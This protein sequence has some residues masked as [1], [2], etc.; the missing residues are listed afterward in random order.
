MKKSEN[1][2]LLSWVKKIKSLEFL[3]SFECECGEKNITKLC[4]H[5]IEN[6]EKEEKIS[7]MRGLNFE[8]IKKELIKCKV[9]C[10]N[11]HQELHQ[12]DCTIKGSEFK[13]KNKILFMEFLEKDKCDMC[14]YNKCL[15]C[16]DFHHTS[17]ENKTI[18]FRIFRKKIN[19]ISEIASHIKYELNTCKV[20][21]R[22]CHSE[23]HN[24]K[25]YNDN[26][27]KI[28]EKV[29][30]FKGI[31]GK[32]PVD[33]VIEM[34]KKGIKQVDISNHFKSSRSTISGIIKKY[35]ISIFSK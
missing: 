28:F 32:L 18:E 21:C 33:E 16:L 19:S 12:K 3:N 1:S 17:P 9:M 34:Y 14:G 29:K 31:Q 23:E 4:F 24:S 2:R 8:R 20:I 30:V 5:H 27:D 13:K 35:K 25:F 7:R 11:C 15:D 10:Q 22:N 6:S 26:R